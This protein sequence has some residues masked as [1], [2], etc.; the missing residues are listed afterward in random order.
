MNPIYLNQYFLQISVRLSVPEIQFLDLLNEPCRY[1]LQPLSNSQVVL[2][3]YI[4]DRLLKLLKLIVVLAHGIHINLC[5]PYPRLKRLK[6]LEQDRVV[7][8]LQCLR[9]QDLI[10]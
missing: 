2:I 3:C 10:F 5:Y 1:L 4:K 6:L 7:V 9:N 8:S